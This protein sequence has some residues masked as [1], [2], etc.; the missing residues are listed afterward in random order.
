[1]KFVLKSVQGL[2]NGAHKIEAR[3]LSLGS[4]RLVGLLCVATLEAFDATTGVDELLLASEERVA[5]VAEFDRQDGLGGF[6]RERVPARA[7]NG[8]FA[9]LR[10]NVWLHGVSYWVVA[11]IHDLHG[12]FPAGLYRPLLKGSYTPDT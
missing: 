4:A 5:L 9:V 3:G 6:G 11:L 7:G 12:N 2:V 1:V 10:V 8:R